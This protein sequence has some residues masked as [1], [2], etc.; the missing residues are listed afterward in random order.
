MDRSGDRTGK[1]P[2][3]VQTLRNIA[4]LA[5]AEIEIRV[6]GRS[7]LPGVLALWAEERSSHASVSDRVEDLERLVAESAGTLL[8]AERDG[9]IVGAL[10]AGW[11]GW[12][13]NMY[14]LAVRRDCRRDGIA[15]ALARAGEDHLRERGARRVTALVAH[16][17]DV[18]GPFWDS[19]GY[20]LDP[21]IGRRV[22]N[23]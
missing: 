16:D 10:I 7:D 22:R 4:G 19:V 21:Q 8:V 14:R 11:D 17:D 3:Q 5:G 12:R 6:G 18:A 9:T 23:L 15:T 2:S 13:G 1:S 20:P